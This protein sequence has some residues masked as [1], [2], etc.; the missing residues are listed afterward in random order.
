MA[1]AGAIRACTQAAFAQYV[2]R[3]GRKPA[4]MLADPTPAIMVDEVHI[5][6]NPSAALLGY[7]ICYAKRAEMR[8]DT[9]AVLPDPAGKGVRRRLITYVETLASRQ[10]SADVTLYTNAAMT[11]NLHLYSALGY[12]MTDRCMQDG[13]D[14]VFFRKML[15]QSPS[16]CPL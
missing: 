3:M 10:G 1:D 15:G 5:A 9:V 2:P 12:T 4:P 8:L 13:F 16:G 7:A 14:R 6:A 11:E